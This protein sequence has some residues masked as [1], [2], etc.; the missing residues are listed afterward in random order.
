[1][2]TATATSLKL[3]RLIQAES[4]KVFDA[5]TQPQHLNLWS[6][7]EGMDGSV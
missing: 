6:A 2:T 7:P 4:E 3:T 1:M 5:W